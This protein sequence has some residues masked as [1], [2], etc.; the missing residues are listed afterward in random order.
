MPTSDNSCW[1]AEIN[2]CQVTHAASIDW[3]HC[4]FKDTFLMSLTCVCAHMYLN[5]HLQTSHSYTFRWRFKKS[6]KRY[7]HQRVQVCLHVLGFGW[8]DVLFHTHK[9]WELCKL[10]QCHQCLHEDG[11][12]T[13]YGITCR[14]IKTWVGVDH[15]QLPHRLCK[16]VCT[17]IPN[18]TTYTC[19]TKCQQIGR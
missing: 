17:R 7:S 4:K 16:Y 10:K 15:H 18:V 1:S 3:C 2:L 12:M 14:H 6:T 13:F 11:G 5:T 8:Y 19:F 9:K